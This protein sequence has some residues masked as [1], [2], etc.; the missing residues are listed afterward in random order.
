MI[1]FSC[2]SQT[3]ISEIKVESKSELKPPFANQGEQEDYW[4]QELFKK[5]YKAK[6]Y[7]KYYGEIKVDTINRIRFGKVQS[8]TL[9]GTD[10]KL[11]SIFTNGLFY[12]ELLGSLSL[13]ISDLVELEFLTDSP[14]VKRFR[15]WLF[16]P[17]MA[18]PQVYVFELQN[19]NATEKTDLESWFKQAKLTFLKAGWLII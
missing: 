17:N 4:T 2:S 3:K 6:T 15:F 13:Q 18:N 1:A 16:R 5:E 12:P 11:N 10:S 14:K 7:K 9:S 19:E 8:I